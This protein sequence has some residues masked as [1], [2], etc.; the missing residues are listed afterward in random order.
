ML[1][2]EVFTGLSAVAGGVS[3]VATPEGSVLSMHTSLL[4]GSPFTDYLIAGPFLTVVVGM[5]ML[6]AP[7]ML[8]MRLPLARDLAAISGGSLVIIEIVERAVIGFNPLEV[9]YGGLGVLS[10]GACAPYCLTRVRG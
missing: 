6:G 4:A 9:L 10:L 5:G 7:L 3:F 8:F 1:A 2:L